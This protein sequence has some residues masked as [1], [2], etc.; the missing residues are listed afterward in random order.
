M[1]GGGALLFFVVVLF[2]GVF[3][4]LFHF[5]LVFSFS[6]LLYPDCNLKFT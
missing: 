6:S 5:V 4:V 2:I 1:L 3:L